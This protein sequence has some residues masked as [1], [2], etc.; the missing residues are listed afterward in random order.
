MKCIGGDVLIWTHGQFI[1]ND[2]YIME[3]KPYVKYE[4]QKK[5]TMSLKC[6][7][8]WLRI[9]I[10]WFHHVQVF[11]DNLQRF[12]FNKWYSMIMNNI[13][14]TMKF[15]MFIYRDKSS[16]KNVVLLMD[17]ELW[18]TIKLI[19]TSTMDHELW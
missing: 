9:E 2:K 3:H 16:F 15:I 8:K 11:L 1:T 12:T 6:F 10:A 5:I 4:K 14:Q 7:K 17:D 19:D 13:L 18:I